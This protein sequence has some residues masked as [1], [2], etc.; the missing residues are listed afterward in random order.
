M[1]PPTPGTGP[2]TKTLEE[3]TLENASLRSSLDTLALHA[4]HL[5]RTLHDQ[6]IAASSPSLTSPADTTPRPSRPTPLP[7]PP[8]DG[9][10]AGR[11]GAEDLTRSFMAQAGSVLDLRRLRA[12][13]EKAWKGADEAV[14][15]AG[16]SLGPSA[17]QSRIASLEDEVGQLKAQNEKQVRLIRCS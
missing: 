10:D 14:G 2:N 8:A 6:P 5:E 9:P 12:E 1:S 3:L 13:A 16:P 7:P 11:A 17:E 4:Q 15:R